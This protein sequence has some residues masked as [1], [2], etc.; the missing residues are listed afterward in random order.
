MS[1]LWQL[2]AGEISR[3]VREGKISAV[4][5]VQSSLDRLEAVNPQLKSL[6]VAELKASEAS[7]KALKLGIQIR[8]IDKTDAGEVVSDFTISESDL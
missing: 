1:E 3:R 8:M 5:A 4:E 7:L 2:S 6:L